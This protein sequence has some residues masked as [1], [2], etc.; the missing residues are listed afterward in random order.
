MCFRFCDLV[1]RAAFLETR[2]LK[3]ETAFAIGLDGGGTKTECLI[4]AIDGKILGRGS[5]G[6]SSLTHRAENDVSTAIG[7][8]VRAAAASANVAVQDCCATCGGVAGAGRP[9]PAAG[10]QR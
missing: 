2:N 3:L 6:A 1:L 7:E 9:A 8:A 5:G 4:S 10:P